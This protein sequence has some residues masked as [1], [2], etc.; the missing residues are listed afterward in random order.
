M[1]IGDEFQANF[2]DF[3]IYG[4]VDSYYDK[5]TVWLNIVYTHMLINDT[6]LD[7]LVLEH[8]MPGSRM[9]MKIKYLEPIDEKYIPLEERI[10]NMMIKSS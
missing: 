8:Y 6:L 10:L 7:A 2:G 5:N 4:Y 9:I 1:N 3:I